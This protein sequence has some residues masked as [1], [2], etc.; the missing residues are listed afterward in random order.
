MEGQ[1]MELQVSA[2]KL[3]VGSSFPKVKTKSPVKVC[4]EWGEW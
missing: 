3:E 2:I 4:E 1:Q